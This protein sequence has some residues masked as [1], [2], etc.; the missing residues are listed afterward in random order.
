M[1]IPTKT[2]K[3]EIDFQ[4]KVLLNNLAE[5][6]AHV[7]NQTENVIQMASKI[8]K[9][10]D[11][12]L[13]LTR[14]FGHN[15]LPEAVAKYNA[16]EDLIAITLESNGKQLDEIN[17]LMS[18]ARSNKLDAPNGVYYFRTGLVTVTTMES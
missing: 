16:L 8:R 4:E 5:A 6:A 7:R 18:L 17:A 10:L 13:T 14:N 3:I 1:E 12:G 9:E 11:S 2:Y 15:T